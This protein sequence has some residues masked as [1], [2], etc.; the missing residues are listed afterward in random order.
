M[1]FELLA[2][3]VHLP[4]NNKG[5]WWCGETHI[6]E[7]TLSSP[8]C[9]TGVHYRSLPLDGMPNLANISLSEGDTHKPLVPILGMK[10]LDS[11]HPR[12]LRFR[13][14]LARFQYSIH[15][16]PGRSPHILEKSSYLLVAD[17]FSWFLEV[18]KLNMTT[19][20]SVIEA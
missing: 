4:A 8:C 10:S 12:V 19:V 9:H 20:T 14:R 5:L 17:Y 7:Q 6:G 3:P 16:S 11:L 13:L 1:P 15:H 18:K 2:L